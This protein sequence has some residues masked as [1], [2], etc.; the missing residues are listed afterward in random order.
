MLRIIEKVESVKRW[1]STEPEHTKCLVSD[2]MNPDKG[3]FN[4]TLRNEEV[5]LIEKLNRLATSAKMYPNTMQ[6]IWEKIE[7]FGQMK[8]DQGCYDE[9]ESNQ[10]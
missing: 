5:E 4:V 3:E 6:E 10:E 7:S 1:P 9:S 8:Y 2:E